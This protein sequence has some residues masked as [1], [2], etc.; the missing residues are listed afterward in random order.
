MKKSKLRERIL[1]E[2]ENL[3]SLSCKNAQRSKKYEQLHI[4]LLKKY[5]N[6]TEVSIDYHR[7]RIEMDIVM[8]DKVYNPKEV[9]TY[10]PTLHT[11]LLF[12]NLKKFLRSCIEKD[13]RSIG[14]YAQLLNSFT[15]QESKY[16][17][18]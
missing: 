2:L 6:A 4:A 8:D 15:P 13:D 10:L 14:F 1:M 12:H 9:N 17:L 18:A 3:I 5:Y 7:H 16:S 11:N